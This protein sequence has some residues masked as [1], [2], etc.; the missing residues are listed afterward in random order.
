MSYPHKEA[1]QKHGIAVTDLPAKTQ[2]AITKFD[3]ETDED[4][5]DALDEKIFGDIE[6]FV[7]AKEN[8]RK[9]DEKKAKHAAAKDEIKKKKTDVSGAPTADDGKKKDETAPPPK[10]ERTAFDHIYGRK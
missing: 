5:K 3:A 9:A 2:S 6:D 8:K 4:K 10:K 1:L 7:E